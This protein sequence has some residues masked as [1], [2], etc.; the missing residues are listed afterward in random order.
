MAENTVFDKILLSAQ[1]V[2]ETASTALTPTSVA[3]IREL[4]VYV[5]WGTGVT[6]GVVQIETADDP[7]YAGTW[8]PLAT[9]TYASGAPKQDIVQITGVA[10]YVRARISTAIANGTVTVRAVGN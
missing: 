2:D 10:L 1:S 8:A 4:A 3:H 7:A 6:A 5:S 9:V